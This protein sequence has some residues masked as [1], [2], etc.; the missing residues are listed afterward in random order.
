MVAGNGVL[1]KPSELTPR[2]AEVLHDLFTLAGFPA[3]LLIRLPATREA[4]PQLAEADVDFVHFTGSDRVG[5]K[6][7]ARLGERLIPS[8]LELSG[9][10]AV[11]VLPDADVRLAA[12]SAWFG[13]TLN[14]GQTCLAARRVFV[15]RDV[16]ERFVAELRPLVEASGPVRLVLPGQAE[17]A[18]R[19]VKD[20][21]AKGGEVVRAA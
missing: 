12:R 1:W 4:G 16:Y 18:A 5:R 20:A 11:V 2:T 6:L 8:A 7:A 19:L 10:D 13:T 14:A 15:H 17:Q 21:E 3:D 9:V